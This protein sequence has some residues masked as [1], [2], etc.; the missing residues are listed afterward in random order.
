M[1][2]EDIGSSNLMY[3]GRPR[4]YM[5]PPSWEATG[6]MNNIP[7]AKSLDARS[8]DGEEK[9]SRRLDMRSRQVSKQLL[10]K[11]AFEQKQKLNEALDDAKATELALREL[12][13]SLKAAK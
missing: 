1:T 9:E 2:H 13:G 8:A 5:Q 10:A 11:T 7:P 6:V 4:I 12:L 3:S